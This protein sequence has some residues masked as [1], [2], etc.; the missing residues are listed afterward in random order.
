[1]AKAVLDRL[2]AAVGLLALAPL[3]LLVAVAI[4]LD[5][6][7][8]VLFRQIR[9]GR[10]GRPFRLWKFRS[11]R[12]NAAGP[13]ITTGRDPRIT[14]A[15]AWLRR[16]KID[17]LPQ[18]WNVLVGELSLVGPRPEVPAFVDPA[19]PV[20]QGVLAVKPGITDPAS[21]AYRQEE[22]MLAGAPDPE[23]YYR[24][25]LLPAKLALNLE[26]L[27]TRSFWRDLRLIIRTLQACIS[28]HERTTIHTVQPTH[29]R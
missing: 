9:V 22:Q 24:E 2:G 18:L 17:E 10:G 1:V 21:L 16:Y 5:D 25:V 14:R 8:P 28:P 11:M 19:D 26:Y 6:G 29:H 12:R 15:G 7:F 13:R 3:L 23:H 27:R 20:W 4:V